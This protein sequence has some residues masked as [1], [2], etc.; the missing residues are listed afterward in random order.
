MLETDFITTQVY[1][2]AWSFVSSLKGEYAGPASAAELV[3]NW[4]DE[5]VVVFVNDLVDLA[6]RL[7]IKAGFNAWIRGEEIWGQMIELEESFGPNEDEL[8]HLKAL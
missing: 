3:D 5:G 1:L 8:R 7:N 6:N 2:D 4:T